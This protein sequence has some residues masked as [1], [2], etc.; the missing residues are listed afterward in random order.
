MFALLNIVCYTKHTKQEKGLAS[1][2]IKLIKGVQYEIQ[3]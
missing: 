2:K 1:L 3:I